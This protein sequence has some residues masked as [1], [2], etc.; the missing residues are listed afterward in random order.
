MFFK[1]N[2]EKR[3]K[4]YQPLGD[5]KELEMVENINWEKIKYVFDREKDNVKHRHATEI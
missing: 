2:Q 5:W 3:G 4:H 1:E